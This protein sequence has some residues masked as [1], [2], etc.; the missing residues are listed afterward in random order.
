MGCSF[1]RTKNP[2]GDYYNCG[3][4]VYGV[5]SEGKYVIRKIISNHNHNLMTSEAIKIK[6]AQSQ[7]LIPELIKDSSYRL[8]ISGES[9]TDIFNLMKKAHYPENNCPFTI[10]PLRNYLYNRS[11]KESV[12]YENIIEIY[13]KLKTEQGASKFLLLKSYGEA[14]NLK[15]LAFTFKEQID[16]GIFFFTFYYS[17]L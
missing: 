11:N 4:L 13:E 9:T 12:N 6:L 14:E 17:I 15:G 16:Y 7:K 10:D 5:I 2:E 1:H 8:F 3:A